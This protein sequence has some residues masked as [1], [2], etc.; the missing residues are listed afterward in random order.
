MELLFIALG[1]AIVGLA[2][3][4]LAPWR[5][6]RGV[7]LVPGV[8]VVVATILWLGLTVLGWPWDGGWIWAVTLVAVALVCLVTAV[9]FGR[10][11]SA[12]DTRMLA[13]LSS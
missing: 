1:G 3:H 4:Y 10:A 13:R 2:V 8:G 11:R 9:A 7:L 12:A 6:E 5:L